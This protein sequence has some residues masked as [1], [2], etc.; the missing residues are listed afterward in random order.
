MQVAVDTNT[1]QVSAPTAV[2]NTKIPAL[3]ATVNVSAPVA[4]LPIPTPYDLLAGEIEITIIAPTVAL[5]EVPAPP[6][7]IATTNTINVSAPTADIGYPPISLEADGSA[8]IQVS[9]PE[10]AFDPGEP[11]Q[12]QTFCEPAVE[13]VMGA[14]TD[15]EPWSPNCEVVLMED[16]LVGG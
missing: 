11:P 14:V 6:V 7:F 16:M 15:E 4:L 12:T 13:M 3:T 5:F 1:I 8:V 10:A 2:L 9:V